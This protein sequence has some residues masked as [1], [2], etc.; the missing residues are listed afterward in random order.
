MVRLSPEK[1]HSG[2][3]VRG[4]DPQ[5]WLTGAYPVLSLPPGTPSWV[6]KAP[7]RVG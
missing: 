3:R 2:A 1:G 5:C 4:S 7:S 6:G